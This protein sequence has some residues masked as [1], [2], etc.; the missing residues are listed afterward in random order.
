MLAGRSQEQ[1]SYAKSPTRKIPGVAHHKVTQRIKGAAP[2]S[3]T[4][5][6]RPFGHHL[7]SQ[8]SSRGYQTGIKGLHPKHSGI[9]STRSLDS[10]DK[11]ESGVTSNVTEIFTRQPYSKAE[12]AAI[13]SD[14][15]SK[16][17][18]VRHT[19]RTKRA[20][21]IFSPAPKMVT[22]PLIKRVPESSWLYEE[23]W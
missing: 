16:S 1:S 4:D 11:S 15:A 3:K 5:S 13:Y 9:L 8:G 22:T 20:R 12:M 10:K 6:T 7:S 23:G 14:V 2:V 19:S 17:D 21:K 18:V